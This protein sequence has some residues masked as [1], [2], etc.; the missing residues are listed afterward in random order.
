MK[1]LISLVSIVF[2]LF[3][4]AGSVSAQ[5]QNTFYSPVTPT[6]VVEYSLPFP[7]VLPDHPLYLIKA[8]RDK[9]LLFFTSSPEKRAHLN[10][11]FA[12]KR[13]VMGQL[14]WEKGNKDLSISTISKAEKYLL[15]SALELAAIKKQN[16]IPPGLTDKLELAAKKHE[17]IIMLL[18]ESSIE[19]SV[20]QSFSQAL[21][22][23]HQALQQ[24][25]SVK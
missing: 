7:G 15:S 23:N 1:N 25:Q 14:L 12:D 21:G 2:G 6:P 13:L 10:L 17:E 22:T 9:I 19:E 8:A 20:K 16:N 11:L 5:P 3:L 24:I 4:F 18:S